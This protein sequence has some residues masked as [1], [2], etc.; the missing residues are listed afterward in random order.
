LQLQFLQYLSFANEI[1]KTSELS[2]KS[3]FSAVRSL[4]I[5]VTSFAMHSNGPD[6]AWPRVSI[7]DF[8]IR[9][10]EA[11]ELS[12]AELIAFLP[13]VSSLEKSKWQEY[14]IQNQG[15]IREGLKN[16]GLE[17]E[18]IVAAGTIPEQ[19]YPFSDTGDIMDMN[20]FNSMHVPLWQMGMA[21]TNASIVNLD[22]FT[23]PSFQRQ[24]LDA[25]DIKHEL[26]SEVVDLDFLLEYSMKA[27]ADSAYQPRSYIIEPVMETFEE[28]S[29]VVG[30]IIAVL[31]WK[32]YFV[33]LLPKNTDGFLVDIKDM[34]GAEFTYV[35]NGPQAEYI[36][37]GDQHNKK[38]DSLQ[39]SSQ[40][41]EFARY[42][43]DLD[44]D[45]SRTLCNYEINIYP[46]QIY[47][48][49]FRTNGPITF[50][51]VVI[52]VF[53]FTAGIFLLYDYMVQQRQRK[54]MSAAQRTTAIVASLFPKSIQKRIMDEAEEQ[55]AKENDKGKKRFGFAPKSQLKDFL[56][57]GSTLEQSDLKSKPIADLFPDT[58]IMFADIVGFTA[59][60]SMR[61]PSQVFTL[62]ETIYA[63]FDEIA[64]RRRVFK[65]ETVG[66]CYVAVAGLPEPRRDHH[67]AMARFSR[68][69]LHTFNQLV[70]K[71]EVSLG[72]DTGDLGLRTGLH[73]G[74][75][76]AGVLRGERARFQLFGDTVNTTARMESNGQRGKIHIS[77]ETADLLTLAGKG[78][79]V[80]PREEKIV[81]KGKGELQTFWLD[82]KGDSSKSQHSSGSESGDGP[83]TTET[84]VSNDDENL[85][86]TV[87]ITEASPVKASAGKHQR[88]VDW[89][90]D[91]LMRLLRE[92]NARRKATTD[93]RRDSMV[94]NPCGLRSLE[95]GDIHKRETVL[96]EVEEIVNLPKFDARAAKNQQDPESLDLGTEVLNQLR[97]YVATIAAMYRD[98][99]FHNFE[100]ASH[101]TL[102][103]VKLMSRIVAP[104][105]RGADADGDVEKNLHDHTYGITSDPLTQFA[106][107]F[108]AL[109]HDVD[110]IGVP[111]SQ[112][113][114]E[115]ATVAVV[116][117][118]K[119]VS[120]LLGTC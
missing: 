14:A 105:L 11:R 82:L 12:G 61:E 45:S 3:K 13:L 1:V 64:R 23:H 68:D 57:D 46:T 73:S 118:N 44:A 104:D 80:T 8:E 102:S 87:S 53:F 54:V 29:A 84:Q 114:K 21:P 4:S 90:T 75:V 9:S 19:L 48:D 60:S 93:K 34:C 16:Q 35:I 36:G 18:D 100:Y 20:D 78:H 74:Q 91:I 119:S 17:E 30:F 86:G 120:I 94:E 101:V 24:I 47:E 56:S 2:V 111:N 63:A 52:L 108:A 71:L 112:L 88:L 31:P 70:K 32:S 115:K 40:F 96:D 62:L 43:G 85:G 7:P 89:N 26:L 27:N 39:V 81:A 106:C 95:Q 113:I 116:Y 67:T 66:D 109:I 10:R 76:T 58:T 22:L 97:D 33:D 41:A 15:W 28:D 92:I 38:Y 83:D 42:D 25:M 50:T 37:Q 117:R 49:S 51:L 69:C 79:W 110:H 59:W 72:P 6:A 77:Q 103:T 98:N 99:P 107:V 65:V 5:A 55:A